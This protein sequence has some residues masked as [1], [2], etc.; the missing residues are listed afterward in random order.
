MTNVWIAR[1]RTLQCSVDKSAT[2]LPR[3]SNRSNA[4]NGVAQIFAIN[5]RIN[6]P[7]IYIYIQI[8]RKASFLA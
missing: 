2:K 5:S 8:E 6:E 4:R 1:T 3:N 7:Y